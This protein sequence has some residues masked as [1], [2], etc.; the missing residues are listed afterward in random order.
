MVVNDKIL[1]QSGTPHAKMPV[2]LERGIRIGNIYDSFGPNHY[3]AKDMRRHL[4][5]MRKPVWI[6]DLE[7]E[8]TEAI[9]AIG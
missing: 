4:P 2:I 8:V 1:T 7:A 5:G 6:H 3:S 9:E